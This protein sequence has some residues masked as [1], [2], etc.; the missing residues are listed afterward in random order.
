MFTTV[1]I[2]PLPDLITIQ[3]SDYRINNKRLIINATSTVVSANVV[4]TLQPYVTITGTTYNPDPA[5]G[6]VGNVFTNNL[7]GTYSLT[8]N[9]VPEPACGNPGG[10]QSPV[11][12]Q[13]DGC[14][15][16]NLTGDSGFF[17]L[18]TLSKQHTQPTGLPGLTTRQSPSFRA[19]YTSTGHAAR[20]QSGPTKNSRH[21]V[22]IESGNHMKHRD[23]GFFLPENASKARVKEA[24]NARNNRGEIVKAFSHGQVTRRDLVKMG[25]ITTGGLLMPI[26]GLNPFVNSAYARSP[27]AHHAARWLERC[28][29]P[30]RCRVLMS[31]NPWRPRL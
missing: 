29:S 10:K 16:S 18:L 23:D 22:D 31:C 28:R 21:R 2:D 5:A 12:D 14:V 8:L 19:Y 6:G 4:L 3:V 30:S 20:D 7:N 1:C 17:A 25:L 26:H 9:G 11:P 27:Q 24:E 15:R 13:A